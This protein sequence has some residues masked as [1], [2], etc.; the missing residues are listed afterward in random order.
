MTSRPPGGSNGTWRITRDP[1]LLGAVVI[2]VVQVIL[3]LVPGVTSTQISLINAFAA[4]AVGFAV[5]VMIRS[6]R[7][8]PSLLGLVKAAG[9]L[10][11]GFGLVWSPGAQAALMVLMSA[12][13]A[14]VTRTQVVA[15]VPLRITGEPPAGERV[16]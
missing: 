6:D 8:V 1:A 14:I 5:A 9:S 15:P 2:A 7:W 11:I 3:T 4:A 16:L 10:V 13:T 12:L